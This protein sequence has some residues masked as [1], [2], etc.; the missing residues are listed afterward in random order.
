MDLLAQYSDDEGGAV[1]R[2]APHTVSFHNF[3][4]QNFNRAPRI[5]KADTLLMCPY[6]LE[7][8]I[9]RV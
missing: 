5:L 7:F 1:L 3:K 8:Q 6:C 2:R 4:S 9:P